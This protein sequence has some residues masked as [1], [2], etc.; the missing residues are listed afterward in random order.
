[1]S[2]SPERPVRKSPRRQGHD[3]GQAAA[4]LVTTNVDLRERRFGEIVDGE[5]VLN[6]A[7]KLVEA[8]WQ[9][10]PDRFTGVELDAFVVMPD[11]FHGIVFVGTDP[12]IAPPGLSKVI[13]AFKSEA[14]VLYGRGIREGSFPPVRRA[15]WQRSFHDDVLP[16]PRA[17]E[18]AREY[19]ADNPRKWRER[20]DEGWG[21]R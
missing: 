8:I 16:G 18:L 17:L 6:S 5:M 12:E 4:Y 7:G 3:Y 2:D 21:Q 9:R 15:L 13:Q 10:I 19:I 20:H 11:Q 14:A 1:M